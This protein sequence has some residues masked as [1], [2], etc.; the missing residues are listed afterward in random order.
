MKSLQS[1]M[2]DK[3]SFLKHWELYQK[4]SANHHID[5]IGFLMVP[6]FFLRFSYGFPMVP[7][8]FRWNRTSEPPGDLQNGLLAVEPGAE[9]FQPEL[10]MAGK[11]Y[12]N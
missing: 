10:G 6:A 12:G 7:L 11:T 9:R 1:K 8:P 5:V 2:L 3:D 4:K